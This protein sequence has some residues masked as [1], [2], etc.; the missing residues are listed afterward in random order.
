MELA[1]I[2][3]SLKAND[4]V[5]AV[6]GAGHDV[7]VR[8][9]LP[10]LRDLLSKLKG[11]GFNMLVDFTAVDRLKLPDRDPRF[12][13]TY[14]LMALDLESGLIQA[15]LAVKA[16]VAEGQPIPHTAMD[17]WPSADW[18]EREVW[19]MFGIP[20]ADRPGIKRLL[21]YEEFKGHALRKDY[22]INKRQ[23]L[24]GPKS[25]ERE[26]NPSFN[27]EVPTVTVD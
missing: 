13:V 7:V 22:P 20:V 26:N 1:A 17:L 16:R 12:E 2:L 27:A 9:R 21:L 15:R 10:G 8:V 19:D 3:D 4:A 25:G 5:T 14:R 6:E 24:I 23:P 18:T 11:A